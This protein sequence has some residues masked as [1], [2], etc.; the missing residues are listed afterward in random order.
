MLNTRCCDVHVLLAILVDAR[1]R[2]PK[3]LD[4]RCFGHHDASMR[5]TV[6]LDEDVERLLKDEMHRSRRPF[7]ET[8][9]RAVRAALGGAPAGADRPPFVVT[10]RAMRLRS[11]IDP[12]SLNKLTDDL[13]A[14]AF[15]EHRTRPGGDDRS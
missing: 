14:D 6:T 11:G 2:E 9:N 5:T 10:A 15:V 13:E 4:S 12:A 8:L 1:H 7:K 3:H